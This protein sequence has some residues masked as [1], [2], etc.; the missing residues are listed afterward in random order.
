MANRKIVCD[1][2]EII[3]VDERKNDQVHNLTYDQIIRI[4]ITTCNE[5]SWFRKIPSEK[6][7]VYA[8]KFAE[9]FVFLR[10]KNRQFYEE[11]KIGLEKFAKNNRIPFNNLT[12]SQEK[13]KDYQSQA[14]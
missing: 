8:R 12:D 5:L 7:E 6:I 13:K 11:Y 3:L 4:Q 1:K 14:I 10:S 9:P 2:T